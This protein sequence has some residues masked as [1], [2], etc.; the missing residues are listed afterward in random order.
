M[1]KPGDRAPD[2]TLLDQDGSEFSLSGAGT[3]VLVYFYPSIGTP[4]GG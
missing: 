2:L 4:G 1:L 3:K